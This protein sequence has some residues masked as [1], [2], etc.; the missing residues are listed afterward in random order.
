ML[1]GA[2][3]DRDEESALLRA[4]IR[5]LCNIYV[6]D[7]YYVGQLREGRLDEAVNRAIEQV[8]KAAK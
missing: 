4:A 1:L 8:R 6:V 2:I 3:E 7:D 5:R